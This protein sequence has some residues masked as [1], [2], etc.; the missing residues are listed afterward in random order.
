MSFQF[1]PYE[2][3]PGSQPLS[4][5]TAYENN[6]TWSQYTPEEAAGK[7]P[8][9]HQR[10]LASNIP[11]DHLKVSAEQLQQIQ[12]IYQ[13]D[14]TGN[15]AVDSVYTTSD[16]DQLAASAIMAQQGFDIDARERL[17]NRWSQQWS[18]NSA[19]SEKYV[20]KTR[21]VL[22]LCRCGYDHARHGSKTRHTPVPFTSCLAHAEI[23]YAIDTHKILRIRGYFHHNDACKQ[24]EFTRIPPTPVHPS[25]YMVALAQLRD[26]ASFADVKK[27]N[28]ELFQARSYKDFP[29]P[30]DL[31]ASPYRW[32]L[33]TRDSRSLYRQFNRM[34]GVKVTEKP[35]INV[36]E[37]LDPM[38]PQYNPTIAEA[39]FHYSARASKG[40]RFEACVATDEMNAAAWKYGYENQII[41]DGTFG[42]CDSRLLLFIVMVVDENRKGIPVAFLMFSAPTGNNQSSSGYNTEI[43]TKLIGEWKN[44]LTKCAH[45]HGFPGVVFCPHTCITDTDLKERGALFAVFPSIWL[46]ICRFHLRQCWKNHRNKLLKGKGRLKIDLKNRL[47]RVEDSLVATQTIEDA[48]AVLSKERELL[49]ELGTGKSVQK[50]IEHINYLDSYWTTDNLW[51]S[52]SDF[53]RK[54]AAS[55][56]GC[57]MDGVIPTTN[58]LESFNG[59]LKRKH[60]RRW[61]NG[62]RRIRVDI[63]IQILIIHILPSIFQ[64]RRLYR[65]QELRIAEQVRRLPGGASLLQNRQK[66]RVIPKIAYLL[67]DSE[68]TARAHA[69]LSAGQIGVPTFSQVDNSFVFVCYSSEALEIEAEPVKYAISVGIDGVVT[70]DCLDFKKHGGACK[71]I[72]GALLLLENLRGRGIPIPSI[73]IPTSLVDAHALQTKTAIGRAEK[74]PASEANERPTIRAAAAVADLLREDTAGPLDPDSDDEDG[75]QSDLEDGRNFDVDTDASSDSG[76][77]ND[78]EAA[79]SQRASTNLAALGEQAV[80]RTIWDLRENAPRYGDHAVALKKTVV[81]V[82]TTQRE[83]LAEGRGYLAAIMA[84]LD[85]L[86]LGTPASTQVPAPTPSTQG[87]PG[88]SQREKRTRLLPPSP[89]KRGSKRHE[90]YAAV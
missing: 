20:S 79:P 58:H 41:L 38:S 32:L 24:A 28:R 39:V 60:L 13:R 65:D 15:G 46:L 63:L 9:L 80:S 56:L 27:K 16:E 85:R 18:R 74:A 23:T 19:K 50:A 40:E 22:Y 61:Q 17:D 69:M 66:G 29:S 89:E 87:P 11:L 57:E 33:E 72:R 75:L 4:G 5:A 12:E 90:S 83:A 3:A 6:L 64:E 77:D 71:H 49:M 68:R 88:M 45:R 30:S 7:K 1:V 62:G 81:A 82:S 2:A 47:K 76:D 86:V 8:A 10:T 43:L 34:N 21:R 51:K 73:P 26:G 36:D 25:V 14:A 84:E 42:I 37:W 55:L 59:V 31:H 52:W 70:C 78:D 53:G 44:S 54:V 48:R 35:Q 67:P